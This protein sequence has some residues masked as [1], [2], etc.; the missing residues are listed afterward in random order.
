MGFTQ[1]EVPGTQQET[2]TWLATLGLPTSP[3]TKVFDDF[4]RLVEYCIGWSDRRHQLAYEVDGMV[5]KVNDYLQRELLGTTSKSPRWQVAYKY[6]AEQAVTTLEKI[7]IQVGK[8]GMLTPVAHLT[9]VLLAGT[10]VSRASLH[11]DDEIKRKD[12]RVG[13]KV[14]VEKAGE[15]IPQIVAVKTEERDGSEKVFHFPKHCPA[16]ETEARRD[17]GGVYIRCPNPKCPAKFKNVLEFFAH[18][19]AMDIEGLGPAIIDQL[20]DTGL[21]NS[22]P[23]LFRLTE[24]QLV[25]LERMGKKSAKNLIAAIGGSKSRGLSR[26]LVGLG[27]R[28]V[29]RRAAEIL[30]QHFGNIDGLLVAN[31]AKL[32]EIPEIGPVIAESVERYFQSDEGQRNV[33]GLRELG[34]QLTEELPVAE[35]SGA[36]GSLAGKS[37]VVTGK[38][39]RFSR[40]EIHEYIKAHGGKVASSV[41]S[42]TDYLIAG[43]DAGSKLAKAKSLGVTVLT[44]KEFQSLLPSN[45]QGT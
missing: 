24:D 20:V 32:S 36:G 12:I 22:L 30:A 1:G 37:F 33:N 13:D 9:P 39:S 17:D 26:V 34:V 14:V 41:S 40:E 21:V 38:L 8:T 7:E 16:C 28:H 44:E 35:T 5:I 42:K 2:L 18:R 45:E 15:I 3:E 11:N 25:P 4:D 6:A 19:H 29:G 31:A 10:T 27:I 43:D 23:D